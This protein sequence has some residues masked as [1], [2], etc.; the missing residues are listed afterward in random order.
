[1]HIIWLLCLAINKEAANLKGNLH[2]QVQMLKGR[3]PVDEILKLKQQID[4]GVVDIE[5]I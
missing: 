2:S 4:L 1:M 3:N 5:A